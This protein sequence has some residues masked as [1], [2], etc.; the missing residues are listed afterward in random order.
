MSKTAPR[1]L[2]VEVRSALNYLRKLLQNNRKILKSIDDAY[3]QTILTELKLVPPQYDNEILD[4]IKIV[5]ICIGNINY[6]NIA[7]GLNGLPNHIK[8]MLI[9][10]SVDTFGI[11]KR[12]I[13]NIQ[14]KPV[15]RARIVNLVSKFRP[16]FQCVDE[17][18]KNPLA[19][20]QKISELTDTSDEF[21]N[22]EL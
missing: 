7:R 10:E 22:I 20:V 3:E 16:L 5:K 19:T 12:C 8:S 1:Q 11:F 14:M 2:V 4:I 17:L 18:V 21:N 9:P 13:D 15:D 6:T